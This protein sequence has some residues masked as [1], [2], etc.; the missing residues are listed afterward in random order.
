MRDLIVIGCNGRFPFRSL[1]GCWWLI[2]PCLLASIAPA[3]F[4][5]Q[6]NKLVGSGADPGDLAGVTVD[7]NGVFF[8]GS[9]GADGHAGA[10]SISR[11]NGATWTKLTGTGVTSNAELGFS[12]SVSL[13]G[14]TLI[15]GEPG[16]NGFSG[17]ASIYVT[18]GFI[19]AL[20]EE[21]L[22]GG[23]SAIQ[24]GSAV[25][26]SGDGKTAIVGSPFA[27]CFADPT[28]GTTSC[29]GKA[30]VFALLN[31]VWTHQA[32]LT[33]TDTVGHPFLGSSVAIASDGN[34][35]LVGG[36]GDNTSGFSSAGAA[37]VFVRDPLFGTWAQQSKLFGLGG[38]PS[39]GTRPFGQGFSVALATDGNTAALG[40]PNDNNFVGAIWMFHRSNANW[41]QQGPKLVGTGAVGGA[42]QGWAVSLSGDGQTL[43][44][45][46]PFDNFGKGAV[47]ISAFNGTSWVQ[48]GSKLV[49]TGAVG[50]AQQGSSVSL[51]PDGL[52]LLEGGPADNSNTGA[53]WLFTQ[54]TQPIDFVLTKL[55]VSP[56]PFGNNLFSLDLKAAFE[57]GSS[58]ATLDPTVT[59]IE[60]NVNGVFETLDA[61][62][63][64][65]LPNGRWAYE[66]RG[67]G[68][69]AQLIPEG[70]GQYGFTWEGT[71]GPVSS[72]VVITF[73]IGNFSGQTSAVP[74]RD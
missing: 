11:D 57:L 1:F 2:L 44:S 54:P 27:G 71:T 65:K 6:G 66:D 39:P 33:A 10:V 49:G 67:Q 5:Q 28:L 20:E 17:G 70:G 24:F 48:L 34:T 14:K 26:M 68:N 72:P 74:D 13:D 38:F 51:S 16:K 23:T 9:P 37:W 64:K 15:A 25:A 50:N 22:P 36:P 63:W 35:V 61:L 21:L 47:W 60:L 58:T 7:E 30:D 73:T 59:G 42:G 62:H 55:D 40:G 4:S 69:T 19:W 43:A 56:S 53:A 46:G 3:Q 32:T 52:N 18:N 29:D 31:G 45:G 12:L 41:T 8:L